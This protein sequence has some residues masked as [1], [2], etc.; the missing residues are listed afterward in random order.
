M[1]ERRFG[2]VEQAIDEAKTKIAG[3][4]E[5]NTKKLAGVTASAEED[6]RVFQKEAR[7]R[8]D[9]IE[10]SITRRFTFIGTVFGAL[11]VGGLLTAAAW[12][13][14]ESR[15]KVADR[16]MDLQK[17][18]IQAQAVVAASAKD[19]QQASQKL[20]ELEEQMARDD[21]KLTAAE[22]SLT[23]ATADY[24]SA[25]LNLDALAQTA[26]NAE[27]SLATATADYQSTKGNLDNLT[28]RAGEL[29]NAATL[30]AHNP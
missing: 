10:S 1:S 18:I 3:A 28:K 22:N 30:P 29:I 26:S 6:M 17:D 15:S 27:H 21:G 2:D 5:E 8:L 19:I 24:Q 14:E 11:V 4:I 12:S 16:V 25:K 23:K 20:K 13:I 9:Q 7:D